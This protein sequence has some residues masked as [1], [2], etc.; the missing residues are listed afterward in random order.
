VL[1]C[2]GKD[3]E[4]STPKSLFS[5]AFSRGTIPTYVVKGLEEPWEPEIKETI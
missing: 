1:G 2:G 3:A 5:A 4:N